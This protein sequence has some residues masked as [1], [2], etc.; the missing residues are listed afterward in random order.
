MKYPSFHIMQIAP[1]YTT[2]KAFFASCANKGALFAYNVLAWAM[3]A[4]TTESEDAPIADSEKKPVEGVHPVGLVG[5]VTLTV[6]ESIP[7]FIGYED[8]AVSLNT[9]TWYRDRAAKIYERLRADRLDVFEEIRK[10][11]AAEIPGA[12]IPKAAHGDI[13]GV[14]APIAWE[15]ARRRLGLPVNAWVV[16]EAEPDPEDLED[17]EDDESSEDQDQPE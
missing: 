7:T 1:A 5:P 13:L 16:L 17:P 9:T 10:L 4:I 2:Q 6:A 3:I 12:A 14:P 11:E 8:Q 15:R